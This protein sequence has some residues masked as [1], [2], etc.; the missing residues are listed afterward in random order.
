[1]CVLLWGWSFLSL[2]LGLP[3]AAPPKSALHPMGADR[4]PARHTLLAAG[5]RPATQCPF[6]FLPRFRFGAGAV[7]GS[8]QLGYL[9]LIM[10]QEETSAVGCGEAFRAP[11]P[12]QRAVCFDYER[13]NLFAMC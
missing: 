10:M 7:A 2:R 4:E 5:G 8:R 3:P 6:S 9:M 1:M 12:Q 11:V 13:L